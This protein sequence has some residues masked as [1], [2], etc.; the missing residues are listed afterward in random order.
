MALRPNPFLLSCVCALAAAP[1]SAGAPPL[2]GCYMRVYDAAELKTRPGQLVG[3]AQVSVV[4]TAVPETPGE[5]E[6]VVADAL[7]A[8]WSGETAFTTIG[9]CHEEGASL[10]CNAAGSD[11]KK[12]ICQT[13]EDGVRNCRIALA[14]PGSFRL[15]QTP[16]GLL[17]TVRERLELPGPEGGPYLYLD[18]DNAAN[19]AFLLRPAPEAACK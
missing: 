11:E 16:E 8:L 7:L 12:P 5:T 10:V 14:E 3:R 2:A 18:P 1:A 6:P 13:R 4:R 15:A 17:L 19:R 9:A